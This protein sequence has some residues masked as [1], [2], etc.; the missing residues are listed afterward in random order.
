MN[1]KTSA[2]VEFSA[3]LP[4]GLPSFETSAVRRGK[5]E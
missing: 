5:V 4:A 2:V 1:V 3:N